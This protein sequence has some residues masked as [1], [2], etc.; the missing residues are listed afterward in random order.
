MNVV[1]GLGVVAA[2]ASAECVT[3]VALLSESVR[4]LNLALRLYH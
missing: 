2:A 3:R 4:R 1:V